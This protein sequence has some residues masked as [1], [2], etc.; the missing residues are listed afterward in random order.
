MSDS[1]VEFHCVFTSIIGSTA[2]WTLAFWQSMKLFWRPDV[3]VINTASILC[4]MKVI[5]RTSKIWWNTHFLYYLC[6]TWFHGRHLI[7]SSVALRSKSLTL[8]IEYAFILFKLLIALIGF[9]QLGALLH[10]DCSWM[11]LKPAVWCVQSKVCGLSMQAT[12]LQ[13]PRVLIAAR[14][15]SSDSRKHYQ[16]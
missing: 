16:S 10:R 14:L 9:P 7:D 11:H 6:K 12:V 5:F 3:S 13:R 4:Y 1:S 15:S 8:P 2:M